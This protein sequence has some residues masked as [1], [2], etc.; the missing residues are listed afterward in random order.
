MMSFGLSILFLCALICHVTAT[1]NVFVLTYF[2]AGSNCTVASGKAQEKFAMNV[3]NDNHETYTD[4]G[5][6]S[7]P[8]VAKQVFSDDHCKVWKSTTSYPMNAC[9]NLDSKNDMYTSE[10]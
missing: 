1:H 9:K 10:Y 2:V 7:G 8:S 3:C 4:V 5:M 6:W